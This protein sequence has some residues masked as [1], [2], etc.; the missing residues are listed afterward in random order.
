MEATQE[1][2]LEE[3]CIE[4]HAPVKSDI[5][6]AYFKDI[7]DLEFEGMPDDYHNF[8]TARI[9]DSQYLMNAG[10]DHY[11]VDIESLTAKYAA[12]GNHISGLTNW[13]IVGKYI[14]LVTPTHFHIFRDLHCIGTI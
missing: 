8:Y 2:G 1:F 9:K 7:K 12:I 10:K 5:P 11:L 3:V 4:S 14:L 13:F 6:K